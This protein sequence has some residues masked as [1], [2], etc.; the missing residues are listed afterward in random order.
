MLRIPLEKM[1][2]NELTEM[3]TDY[4]SSLIVVPEAEEIIVMNKY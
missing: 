1:P 2:L 4:E 3:Q